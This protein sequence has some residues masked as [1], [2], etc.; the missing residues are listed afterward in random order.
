LRGEKKTHQPAVCQSD[1]ESQGKKKAKT[2]LAPL[3]RN[4]RDGDGNILADV[5]GDIFR[6]ESKLDRSSKMKTTR[7]GY[8][9]VQLIYR[10]KGREPERWSYLQ[11]TLL[12]VLPSSSEKTRRLDSEISDLFLSTVEQA[13]RVLGLGEI[14]LLLDPANEQ[15][16]GQHQQKA[17]GAGPRAMKKEGLTL[18]SRQR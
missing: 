10:H 13:R 14:P 12:R 6:T 16:R 3:S 11:R 5:D 1:R 17:L 2:Y 9:S 7:Q 4:V 18:S 8:T 15:A